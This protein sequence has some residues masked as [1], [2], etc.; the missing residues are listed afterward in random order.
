MITLHHLEE[1]R[2][3]RTLWLLEEL[4]VKY[5]IK[6]YKR[7]KVGLAPPELK[8]VHP[9]G[10]SPVITDGD[11]TIAESGAITEYLID[12]Y[13]KGLFKPLPGSPEAMCN[14][15]WMHYAEGSLMPFMLLTIIFNRV[16]QAPWLVRPIT[17]GISGQVKK[18][19]I[20]P[21]IKTHLGFV[22]SELADREWFCGDTLTGADFQMVIP[23]NAARTNGFTRAHPNI[24]AYL[25]RVHARPA[26]KAALQRGA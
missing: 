26:Y 22:E 24:E 7:T 9:L 13:G 10:K 11:L 19:F 15:Y 21:N 6:H 12:T 18:A 1:S 2:S 25:A 8:A 5:E 16:E 23:L 17:K 4:G 14:T 20:N 3:T